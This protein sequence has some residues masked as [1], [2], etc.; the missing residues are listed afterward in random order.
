M[1]RRLHIFIFVAVQ[2]FTVHA[3]LVVVRWPRMSTILQVALL[4]AVKLSH[5][6]SE[7]IEPKLANSSV[8][9][10]RRREKTHIIIPQVYTAANCEFSASLVVICGS[11]WPCSCSSAASRL[12]FFRQIVPLP[13]CLYSS[14][15][16]CAF[17]VCCNRFCSFD[18]PPAQIFGLRVLELKEQGVSEEQ[19]MAVA[20]VWIAYYSFIHILLLNLFGQ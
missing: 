4:S 6:L 9:S 5:T 12:P 7:S 8:H 13:S 1:Y 3:Y 20:N 14:S 16:D 2:P 18:P 17:T 10:T 11:S 15:S 19:A